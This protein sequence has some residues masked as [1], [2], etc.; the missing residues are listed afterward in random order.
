MRRKSERAKA[1]P[2]VKQPE[3]V[4][5]RRT[6]RR[7]K[8]SPEKSITEED[9]DNSSGQA[10][11]SDN[12][13]QEVVTTKRAKRLSRAEK[14]VIDEVKERPTRGKRKTSVRSNETNEDDSA[15][16]APTTAAT[17]KPETIAEEEKS[18]N[19][20]KQHDNGSGENAAEIQATAENVAEKPDAGAVAD[21]G[22][23]TTNANA[24]DGD[25]GD[26]NDAAVAQT[27]VKSADTIDSTDEG[28]G[29]G[30]VGDGG[31]VDAQKTDREVIPEEAGDAV[32][33]PS[34]AESASS[35]NHTNELNDFSATAAVACNKTNNISERT[36]D[37]TSK[38]NSRKEVA[39]DAA[40]TPVAPAPAAAA[41]VTAPAAATDDDRI[42]RCTDG[43][44]TDESSHLSRSAARKNELGRDRDSVRS[45]VEHR[46]ERKSL[47]LIDDKEKENSPKPNTPAK[48]I[49]R[50]R[51]WLSSK[52]LATRKEEIAISSD[53]LKGLI[54]DVKPVPLSDINLESNS[55]PETEEPTNEIESESDDE[56][57]LTRT[58][59]I[60]S[61]R[62]SEERIV[63]VVPTE[64]VAT[65]NAASNSLA[66]KVSIVPDANLGRP[67]SP[68][69][70]NPSCILYITN[71]VRPFTALQL[72]G[73]LARTGKIV[74]NGFWMDKI[75]SKCY[76]KF[77]TEE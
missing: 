29:G 56:K 76:V 32:D 39:A 38:D 67:P 60:D 65:I 47:E 69:K 40:A 25:G 73:L 44:K 41:A 64:A 58:I 57:S 43:E 36:V 72:R 26:A 63:T 37:G 75:K 59:S 30:K 28:G 50:K 62:R 46:K 7:N 17:N 14:S 51:K 9:S 52:N 11:D 2:S 68:A 77:E 55:E 45:P 21:R 20:D 23:D 18:E 70:Y 15:S 22:G 1:S 53:S 13:V 6:T 71:L 12:D 31:D 74:D 48:P 35:S 5:T 4:P 16:E 49:V 8:K 33:I 54:P 34:T 42:K 61:N 24:A 66:R 10:S 3:S 19:V 27:E